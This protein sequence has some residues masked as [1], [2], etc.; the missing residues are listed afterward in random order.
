M[1]DLQDFIKKLETEFK[2]EMTTDLVALGKYSKDASLLEVKPQ[3]VVFPADVVDLKFLIKTINFF[4]QAGFRLPLTVRSAGT[5]MSGGAIGEGVVA[6]V[7]RH[8]T[9]GLKVEMG[10]AR[11]LP[12]T[13]Y[14]DFEKA[15]LATGQILPSYTA[16]KNLCTVGGMVANNSGGEKT[17]RYGKTED[18]IKSLKVIFADGKEYEVRPLNKDELNKKMT[19]GDYEG[20]IYKKIFSLIKHNQE[21][22]KK[23]KPKV[24]KNSAGYYLWNVWDGETFDLAK[25]IVGSQ[26]TLAIVTDI[27]FKLVP[28][29]KETRLVAIFL[30]DLKLVSNLVNDLLP[31]APD[32]IESYDEH[33]LKL[34]L[35]FLPAMLKIM[36]TKN[37]FKLAWGFLPELKMVLTGGLPK[38]VVLVEF[39]GADERAVE[40]KVAGAL[41]ITT[42]YEVQARATK[43]EAEAE[44]YWTFRRE[45]FNL[46]RKHI[47]GRRTAPFIDDIIVKPEYL[48]EFLPK[49]QAMLDEYDLLYTVAGHV[50]DGN[51]HIIPLMN[52]T[53]KKNRQIIMD[54]SE[55]VYDLVIEYNGSITAEHNDGIIRTPFLRKMYG[56]EVVELFKEVKEIFDP[57]NIFNPGK[58]VGTDKAYLESH[59]ARE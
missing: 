42:K 36:K 9:G 56:P 39:A 37:L 25:L 34:A 41:A 57:L 8:L 2:G 5:D 12:G 24:S 21:L 35:K 48:P 15:T 14:R 3:L 45:S 30:P 49:L 53:N 50:G 18:Y 59:L 33:T 13:F 27:T 40:A 16:S 23:A 7:N 38:L 17:L 29:E 31:L 54:L 1:P 6:D 28:V 4:H 22:I 44:K 58:K 43:N 55:R 19:Q 46:L 47:H 20:E 26:G 11:V 52:M 10:E 51:F 32:S